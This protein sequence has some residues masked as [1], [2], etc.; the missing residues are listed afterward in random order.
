MCPYILNQTE[1]IL[2][3]ID[4]LKLTKAKTVTFIS[5]NQI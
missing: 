5:Q 1:Y 2:F 3:M 4:E